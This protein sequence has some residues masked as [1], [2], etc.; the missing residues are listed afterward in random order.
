MQKMRICDDTL[1]SI[2]DLLYSDG[3]SLSELEIE[4]ALG[5]KVR[6]E[7][8]MLLGQESDPQDCAAVFYDSLDL[9][10]Q[11]L[12]GEIEEWARKGRY[13]VEEV[14]EYIEVLEVKRLRFTVK[15]EVLVKF[16]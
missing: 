11:H 6:P 12:P 13:T 2:R 16:D 9:L 1:T 3:I 10:K 15:R 4:A 7:Y 5:N 8:L 14:G